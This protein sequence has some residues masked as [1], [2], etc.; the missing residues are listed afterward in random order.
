MMKPRLR[1]W[2]K[3]KSFT[4]YGYAEWIGEGVTAKQAYRDYMLTNRLDTGE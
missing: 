3:I 4:C 2:H 1:Y